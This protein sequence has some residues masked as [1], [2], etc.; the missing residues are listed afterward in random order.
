MAQTTKDAIAGQT[1]MVPVAHPVLRDLT[2]DCVAAFQRARK[3]Y[4]QVMKDHKNAGSTAEPVTLKSSIEPPLRKTPQ[5]RA[6]HPSHLRFSTAMVVPTIH[7]A[8][9]MSPSRAR[10]IRKKRRGICVI[11]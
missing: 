3:E 11:G 10:I 1:L 5:P 2:G 8:T 7:S 4:L 9:T 6:H